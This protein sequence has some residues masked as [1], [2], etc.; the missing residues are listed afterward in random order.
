MDR[1]GASKSIWQHAVGNYI[2]AND[3]DEHTVYDVLVI[4][5]GITGLTTA[6]LLQESGQKCLLVEGH[7]IGFGT[8]GGT[9]AHL[10]TVLD[11]PYIDIARHF[12]HD[13]ACLVAKGA[14]EAIDLIEQFTNKY[15]IENDLAYKTGYLFATTG[16]EA[17]MLQ[18]MME[19]SDRAGVP[20]QRSDILPVPIPY[21]KAASVARQA[22]M[23]ALKHLLGLARVFEMKGGVI[24]QQCMVH[25]LHDD[26]IITAETSQGVIRARY[27]VYATHLPPGVNVFSFRCA[28]YRSYAI[29]F[30]LKSGEYPDAMVYDLKEPYHY[31]R[32]QVVDGVK[33]VIAG[34]LD[35][36]TGHNEDTAHVQRELELY[37]RQYFDIDTVAYRWSSQYYN[38]VDGL[39]Y[40]GLMPGHSK[41]YAA[42]GFGGN[43]MIYGTLS[44]KIL[45]DLITKG[46]SSYEK[47]FDP[48]RIKLAGLGT[49][50]KENADVIHQFVA[51]RFSAEE[52][53]ELSGIAPGEAKMGEW[54]GQKL[55][56]YKSDEGKLHILSAICPHVGCTVKWNSAECTWDCPCHGARYSPDGHLL[57]GPA[58][59]GLTPVR[60]WGKADEGNKDSREDKPAA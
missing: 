56:I 47:L 21:V 45:C 6:L 40:I 55:A 46:T 18:E 37:M 33:Y 8:T 3:R 24:V 43:G 7:N 15:G 14:R 4:G 9:T 27:A 51:G 5:G 22:Q 28:P 34:G 60:P 41:V 48:G 23:H 32:S 44:G 53:E 12:G 49:F 58:Q 39:P 54:E 16:E 20:M 30:T 11:T 13:A 29:A 57:T 10:N 35:H 25:K 38:S 42:T 17:D 19:A 26:D 2:P 59:K 50:L 52:I 31:Y 36:K 1:D